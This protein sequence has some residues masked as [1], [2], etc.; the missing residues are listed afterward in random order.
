MQTY[1]DILSSL[2]WCG[3]VT[4]KICPSILDTLYISD[5]CQ[6][7]VSFLLQQYKDV[8]MQ[9]FVTYYPA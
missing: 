8:V 3:E 6:K 1:N 7:L 4:P 9:S 2:L 5:L